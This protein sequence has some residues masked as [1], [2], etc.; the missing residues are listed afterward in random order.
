[1]RVKCFSKAAPAG[2]MALS[3]YALA[4]ACIASAIQLVYSDYR[5]YGE[6]YLGNYIPHSPV[7]I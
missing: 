4:F 2:L 7:D 3:R 6:Y 1:M 5:L